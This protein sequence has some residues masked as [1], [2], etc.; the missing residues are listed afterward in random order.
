MASPYFSLINGT[1]VLNSRTF[2]GFSDGS[3]AFSIDPIVIANVKYGADGQFVAIG[4][5]TR[6]TNASL[7]LLPNSDDVKFLSSIA[8]QNKKGAGIVLNGSYVNHLNGSQLKLVTGII[9]SY[10]PYPTQGKGEIGDMEYII[11]F[12]EVNGDFSAASFT[13]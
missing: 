4:T 8:E 1:L 2:T 10:Q 6:G 5:G 12:A 7:K 9:T 13:N 3:D 11:A